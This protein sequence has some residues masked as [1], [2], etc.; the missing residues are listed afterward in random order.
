MSANVTQAIDGLTATMT[1]INTSF[2]TFTSIMLLF[3]AAL[4]IVKLFEVILL[5][6]VLGLM[7]WWRDMIGYIIAALILIFIGAQWIADYPGVS[8]TLFGL[9]A[10]MF[11]KA[12]VIALTA[13]GS[14]RG[15]SQFKAIWAK[16]RGK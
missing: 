1:G 3:V 7:I 16:V 4:Q 9:S 12:V 13:G 5:L 10:Y 11:L 2:D 14:S 6:G 15:W 8:I